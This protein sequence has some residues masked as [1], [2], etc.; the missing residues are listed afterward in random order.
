M[1]DNRFVRL[2]KLEKLI[3]VAPLFK[4]EHELRR[5]RFGYCVIR[6]VN[7]ILHGVQFIL[8]LPQRGTQFS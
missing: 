4:T 8:P 6:I 2:E 7:H 1:S 5:R 3:F